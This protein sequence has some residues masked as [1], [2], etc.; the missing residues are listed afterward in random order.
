MDFNE[1]TQSQNAATQTKQ[2]ESSPLGTV[3]RAAWEIMFY[4]DAARK[5][6]Y[7]EK[8]QLT[9]TDA[10]KNAQYPEHYNHFGQYEWTKDK[11]RD[12]ATGAADKFANSYWLS[13]MGATGVGIVGLSTMGA[14]AGTIAA[15]AAPVA[16]TVA[17][18][19]AVGS[20]VSLGF[21]GM[22]TVAESK[23]EVIGLGRAWE[24]N[25]GTET[26]IVKGAVKA[27][28]IGIK[29]T[30]A[31]ILALSL[32]STVGIAP[33]IAVSAFAGVLGVGAYAVSAA[34]KFKS[35][36]VEAIKAPTPSATGPS[37]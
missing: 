32:V 31:T 3:A 8:S 22:R 35:N 12:V 27:A 5:L 18:V 6:K 2:T 26:K 7:G 36:F 30:V 24:N 9:N 20:A 10:W 13:G 29:G 19:L 28:D 21:K 25:F 17:A 33:L 11:I 34:N 23:S 1:V 16:L 37:K 15:A 4:S 14:A